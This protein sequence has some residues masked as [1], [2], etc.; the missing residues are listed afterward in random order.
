MQLVTHSNNIAVIRRFITVL[1]ERKSS[2]L[3]NKEE[4]EEMIRAL[5]AALIAL[6]E[7][8]LA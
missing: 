1:R 7:Q 8:I 6:E 4:C 3:Y 2:P 5:E